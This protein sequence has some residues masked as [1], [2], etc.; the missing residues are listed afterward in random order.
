[1]RCPLHEA[2][3]RFGDAPALIQLTQDRPRVF[4]FQD[5]DRAAQ[6]L[7]P[8]VRG[9]GVLAIEQPNT[10]FG[11]ALLFAALRE[12]RPVVVLSHRIPDTEVTAIC[13]RMQVTLRRSAT[14]MSW[15]T[16]PPSA[17]YTT[18]CDGVATILMTSG[19]SGR[20]KA[21]THTV[22]A[23]MANA[24]G[25]AQNIPFGVGDTWL[26]SLSIHHIGGL[27]L[28]FR[29]LHGGGAIAFPHENDRITQSCRRI[30][31]THLSVVAT[32]LAELLRGEPLATL[33]AVLVGGGPIPP[34][35]VERA[36]QAGMPIHTTYGMTEMGSQ[37]TTTPPHATAGQL[38]TAGRVLAGRE[39]HIAQDG[40]ILVRG[41]TLM[42]GYRTDD[43]ALNVGLDDA[44]WFH[45]GD[46]GVI[47]NGW[48]RVTGRKD[49]MF[50]SGGENI[51]P[52]EIER[53]MMN[54]T[55]VHA[56]VVVSVPN[57]K[58]GARPV[59]FAKTTHTED[60]LLM[61]LR[62]HLAHFQVPD[63][64]HPWPDDAPGWAGKPPRQW[65]SQ[66]AA[67]LHKTTTPPSPTSP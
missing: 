19:S 21:V 18:V 7:R 52:E 23:H 45:T 14:G 62:D 46:V 1:M 37:V 53:A 4:G 51:H 32:Q 64:V 44:G 49:H 28:L 57:A 11:A 15:P 2:S 17:Q 5:W 6:A 41:D 38:R 66:R 16:A 20:P 50:I 12:H 39:V 36:V 43:G 10:P 33:N 24:S 67:A 30:A 42:C 59:A 60:D 54:I 29:S 9:H 3:L 48:L 65:F 40:E 34:A 31:I 22:A 26:Q 63:R 56:A 8:Q 13:Q 55:G 25:S 58:W 27:A 47:E 61:A 35:L